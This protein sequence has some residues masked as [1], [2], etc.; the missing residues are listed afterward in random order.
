MLNYPLMAVAEPSWYADSG[1][2]GLIAPAGVVTNE[3]EINEAIQRFELLQAALVEPDFSENIWTIETIKRRNPPHWSF[4]RQDR[5]F[6]W[7]HYGDLL[8]AGQSPCSLH[9]DWPYSMLLHYLR[10]GNRQ[11]FDTAAAMAKHRYDIDQY[12]GGRTDKKGNQFWR[13]YMAFYETDAHA[14]PSISRYM[15]SRVSKNS[16]TWNGGLVLYYL[17]TGD[18]KAW[19]AAVENGQTALNY[20]AKKADTPSC[21]VSE[22]RQETWPMLNLINLYRVNGNPEYLRVARNLA[23]NR[24]LYREQ[25]AGGSGRF[26]SGNDCDAINGSRQ[27]NTMYAYAINPL[28]QIHYETRDEELAKLL[29]RMAD[30]TRNHLLFGGDVN[31]SGE[32]R[33]LQSLYI[34]LAD[35]P[36]G[37]REGKKGEVVKDIFWADLFAYAYRL[38]GDQVYLEWARKCFRDGMFYYT[39][40]GSK[41]FD[42]KWRAKISFKDGM[43]SG[44]ETKVHG[45]LGCTGQV[46]LN[47]EYIHR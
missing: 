3:P 33:P 47:T 44:S 12:H 24:L 16:H 20:Y 5:F 6:G 9:Y 11:F 36:E 30:F 22:T 15:P 21:A 43:F 40:G 2:L 34:W 29:I 45:W 42:P 25:Q 41:Y 8:W 32:Y 1:A 38:T 18:V 14:D 37:V 7:M 35:D 31:N 17:L 10:T 28:I 23:K 39:A 4:N 46:Y 26:G 27:A 13:N 19:E